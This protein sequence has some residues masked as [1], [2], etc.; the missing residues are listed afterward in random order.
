M[1]AIFL[2][3]VFVLIPLMIIPE[4][5]SACIL[6]EETGKYMEPCQGLPTL[7]I[8]SLKQ[9]ILD[10]TPLHEIKCPNSDHVLTQRPNSNLACVT[11]STAEKLDWQLI[12]TGSIIN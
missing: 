9:Q 4:S 12:Y 10:N 11:M 7:P 8:P 2:L 1:K 3:I 5:F 6:D